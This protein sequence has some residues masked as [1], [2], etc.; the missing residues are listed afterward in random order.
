MDETNAGGNET[1][2]SQR[3]EQEKKIEGIAIDERLGHRRGYA[4]YALRKQNFALL[5]M[6]A[7][8]DDPVS[9]AAS[10]EKSS[11]SPHSRVCRTRRK[12]L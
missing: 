6:S 11:T 9:R 5:K 1:T 12:V 7:A 2:R 10:E 3:K 8:V 4:I